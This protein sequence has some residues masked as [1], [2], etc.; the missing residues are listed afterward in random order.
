MNLSP[1]KDGSP[2]IIHFWRHSS[3][4]KMWQKT[5]CWGETEGRIKS[6]HWWD[7]KMSRALCRR[8]HDFMAPEDCNKPSDSFLHCSIT[9]SYILVHRIIQIWGRYWKFINH[10][11]LF[12]LQSWFRIEPRHQLLAESSMSTSRKLSCSPHTWPLQPYE[13]HLP[14]L[15]IQNRQ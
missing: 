1:E 2:F 15:W 9:L 12:T 13:I 7:V 11:S 10:S 14:R 5:S 6:R 8:A 3:F 4:T